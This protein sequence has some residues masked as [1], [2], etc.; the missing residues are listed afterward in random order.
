MVTWKGLVNFLQ[1]MQL[2]QKIL[3]DNDYEISKEFV[4]N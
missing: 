1:Y 4:Y 2:L 3:G